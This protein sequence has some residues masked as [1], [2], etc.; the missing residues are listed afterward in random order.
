MKNI[1]RLKQAIL[2]ISFAWVI[3]SCTKDLGNYNY[4]APEEPQL[5]ELDSVY[6][7]YV[8]DSLKIKPKVTF[9]NPAQL[10]YEWKISIPEQFRSEEY[11][12]EELNLFFGYGAKRYKARLAIVDNE[13]GMKYFHDFII[14]GRTA[15][16]Q[17]ITVLSAEM[18]KSILS[19]IKQD[20]TVQGHLYEGMHQ[21]PLPNSPLALLALHG[22]FNQASMR[23]YWIITKEGE[24][25]GVQIDIDNFQRIKY[26]N[27][28]FFNTQLSIKP[29][30]LASTINGVL[31]GVINGKL[32]VGTSSTWDMNPVYGMFGN[33]TPG[34]YHLSPHLIYHFDAS[35]YQGYMV[36]YDIAL[37]QLILFNYNAS[38]IGNNYVVVGASFDPKKMPIEPLHLQRISDESN[39]AF[40]KNTDGEIIEFKFGVILSS[41]INQITAVDKRPFAGQHLITENTKWQGTNTEI[42]YFTSHDKIY[43]YNPLNEDI[44]ALDTDFGGKEVSMIKLDETGKRLWAGVEGSLYELDVNTGKYGDI[45][46][47]VDGISGAPVDIYIRK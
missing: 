13:N 27:D 44:R 3:T 32:Y 21:E 19:F 6:I 24:K 9:S 43:R 15:F 4:I 28:N 39:Y 10:S 25:P 47:K 14:E 46:Q 12:G 38:F 35:T 37:Q 26:I 41:A 11:E 40:G 34:D 31:T 8:G 1:K 36:G 30:Y 42:F 17:G 20:G 18:N 16:S 5:I 7:A 22:N 2:L 45:L 29:Q 23:S 33:P